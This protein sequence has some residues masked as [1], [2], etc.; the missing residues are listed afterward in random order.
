M[1]LRYLEGEVSLSFVLTSGAAIHDK[2]STKLSQDLLDAT[3][4]LAYLAGQVNP[5]KPY[6][7]IE[8]QRIE[9][10]LVTIMQQLQK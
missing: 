10:K 3:A 5:K 2:L 1:I 9:D 6:T 7:F 4:T 8:H